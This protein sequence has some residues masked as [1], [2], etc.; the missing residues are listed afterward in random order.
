MTWSYAA[1]QAIWIG[2]VLK[3]MKVEVKKPT[4]LP[5]DNKFAI[6]LARNP[7]LYEMRIVNNVVSLLLK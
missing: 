3:E 2:S 5:I 4:I 6:N 1:Y 7:V